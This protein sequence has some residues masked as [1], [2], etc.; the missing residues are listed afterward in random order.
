MVSFPRRAG[1]VDE[2]VGAQVGEPFFC[3][4]GKAGA[5]GGTNASWHPLP[6]HCLDT[7]A[8]AAAWLD[9]DPNLGRGLCYGN[10]AS[11]EKTRA[12]T[13]FFIAL[14]DLGK[15]DIR[16]QGKAPA[17]AAGLH[18]VFAEG[19]YIREPRFDHGAAGYHWFTRET[20]EYGLAARGA[21]DWALAVTGHHGHNAATPPGLSAFLADERVKAQDAAA[22]AA[23]V[24]AAAGLFLAP[25][26]VKTH[27]DPGPVPGM[28]AGFCC[29]CDWLASNEDYFPYV[30]HVP[31][32]LNAY[33]LSRRGSAFA[34]RALADSGLLPAKL[35]GQ[36]IATVLPGMTAR[37]VQK[38]V[39]D[40][41]LRPGLTLIEAST[42]SGK[43]EAALAYASRLIGAGLADGIVLALPTQA[44][45]NA[46]FD[47]AQQA[48]GRLFADGANLVLAH[49]K[50]RYNPL[51]KLLKA[52]GNAPT[53]QGSEEGLFQ[54]A[55]W[56]SESRKRVFLGQVG[57]CTIDQVL[58][59]VLP[60]RHAFVRAFGIRRGVLIVDEV[61]AYDSYMNGLLD[62]VIAEQFR[63]GASV[64]LLSATLPAKRRA[65]LLA[66]Y[67][68][69]AAVE[70]ETR[71]PY[72]L[73]SGAG[74]DSSFSRPA[75]PAGPARVVQ[76]RLESTP[77]ALLTDNLVSEI[78]M[79]AA[80]GQRIAVICNV[81]ADA[82]QH[83]RRLRA[84]VRQPVDVFHS[85]YRFGD[86]QEIEQHVIRDYGKDAPREGPG[87]VLV[88]TQVVEQSLD[89]DFDWMVTQICPVDLLFQRLGRLH[90]HQR[91]GRGRA[92]CIV[93]TPLGDGY[94]PH[95][96]VY[97]TPRLLWRTEQLLR[98]QPRLSFPDAYREWIEQAYAEVPWPDEPEAVVQAHDIYLK[99]QHQKRRQAEILSRMDA[100]PI[101]DHPD[102]AASLTRGSEMGLNVVPVLRRGKEDFLLE[103]DTQLSSLAEYE[104]AEQIDRNSI[105][106]PN[107]WRRLLPAMKDGVILLPMI[108]GGSGCWHAEADESSLCYTT[109][110]GLERVDK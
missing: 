16:F 12:W 96:I 48:A 65:E 76:F 98:R 94:R 53:A 6:F 22:R 24:A 60:I 55:R 56:L 88:A 36:G 57:V 30:P 102:K 59:S 49:G 73:I 105:P 1:A 42:G 108:L 52:R 8:V 4:W 31:A 28:L 10:R 33:Y 23:W 35:T 64:V 89:L 95:D 67:A 7:A 90:R 26:G 18:P 81:V 13:L 75:E 109:E 21:R 110:F 50:A 17:L 72:P 37:G 51:Y 61:H 106:V 103:G 84:A 20:Q 97:G 79:R 2:R 74:E 3:Y 100:T 54:C 70:M 86:R 77:D 107:S 68:P 47:R 32:D 25:A 15:L 104:R 91:K 71:A 78:A 19:N 9:A 85:R 14:H 34:G 101:D 40:L 83:A 63:C 92:E 39:D 29:V 99:K 43:T 58:L 46:M 66:L 38:D 27:E 5:S 41:P 44:T 69:P 62:R 45:A 93:L 87:R 11:P 82:Q 80:E